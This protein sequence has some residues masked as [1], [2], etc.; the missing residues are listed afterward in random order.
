[1]QVVYAQG[2]VF[3]ANDGAYK[4]GFTMLEVDGFPK[5]WVR[6]ANMMDEVWVPSTFNVETMR[7]SGVTRPI[8]VIPLGVDPAYFH[9]D[10]EHFPHRKSRTIGGSDEGCFVFLSVFEWGE[11]KAPEILLKAFSEEFSIRDDVVLVCK[12]IN[13]DGSVNVHEQ[14]SRL[15][16]RPDGGRI[17]LSLNDV[18][19]SYQLG[20]LYR[21]ADCFVLSTRGEGWGMPVLEAMACGLPVIATAWG[22]QMD[23]YNETVGY[24]LSVEKL[25]PAQARCPYYT[26]FRWADPSLDHLRILMRH[27]FEHP[28]EA[29][30]KGQ[31]A[32]QEAHSNWTWDHSAK[33]IR[34]RIRNVKI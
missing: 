31:L 2:D 30:H 32:C 33:R 27:V 21:S 34:E 3:A 23:F 6:Q 1:M 12:V 24:P 20:S 26:G 22:A 5:E 14:I 9:P 18:I 29:R 15:K 19:P 7:S 28:E 10:I 16:L 17:I 4:V 13:R 8:H 25:S 11:R